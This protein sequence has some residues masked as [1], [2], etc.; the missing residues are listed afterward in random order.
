MDN[1]AALA[2]WRLW[3]RLTHSRAGDVTPCEPSRGTGPFVRFGETGDG[4]AIAVWAPSGAVERGPVVLLGDGGEIRV[5]A[6]DVPNA[7]A[8]LAACGHVG[9]ADV[10]L[11]G[12]EAGEPEEGLVAW[13]AETFGV[14]PPGDVRA[15]VAGA[16]RRN[17]DVPTG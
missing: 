12:A 2:T 10:V 3:M 16:A 4:D 9:I 15:A 14:R 6:N 8:L 13:L 7:L 5:L 11:R 1:R 17:P